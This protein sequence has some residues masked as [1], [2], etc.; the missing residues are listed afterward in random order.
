MWWKAWMW[1]ILGII[2][3][4][5]CNKWIYHRYYLAQCT[6]SSSDIRRYYL[7]T[8]YKPKLFVVCSPSTVSRSTALGFQILK[9]LPS[10]SFYCL[11]ICCLQVLPI[12][13]ESP[14]EICLQNLLGVVLS[15]K[16][17]LTVFRQVLALICFIFVIVSLSL[18]STVKFGGQSFSS[19]FC[20]TY[21]FHN[22]V[23]LS[24]MPPHTSLLH[25]EESQ[26]FCFPL[27][28]QLLAHDNCLSLYLF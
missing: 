4:V 27:T 24:H 3:S 26:T 13:F 8:V 17:L 20:L 9:V 6:A 1:S 21:C 22:F 11:H 12:L 28:R 10:I 18:L 14:D 15:R 16:L 7:E 5:I 2:C 19:T 23:H 25:I